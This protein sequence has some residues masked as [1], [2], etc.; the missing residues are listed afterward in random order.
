MKIKNMLCLIASTLA[1]ISCTAQ[2]NFETM[3]NEQFKKAIGKVDEVQLVD[4]RTPSEYEAGHINNAILLDC[5]ADSFVSRATAV[6]PKTKTVAVY[7]RSGRRSAMA[8]NL[9]T[10]AGYKVINL[11]GGILGWEGAGNEVVTHDMQVPDSNGYVV[12]EGQPY[13]DFTVTT[14]DGRTVRMRDLRG[15]VV[16]LQFTA[17]WCSVCRREMPHIESDIWQRHRTDS[18]FVLIGIDRDEPLEK[19]VK[20]AEQTGVTYPLALDPSAAVYSKF[21]LKDSGITRNVL[22]NRDGT[23]IFRTRLYK[24]DEF[25]RLVSR[26]DEELAKH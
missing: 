14:T 12:Y 25:K 13:P 10:E 24:E 5:K 17:S 16:M 23:I 1:G 26:I 2:G 18:N 21:A 15:K 19:V 7:C 8:A 22:V 4:V 6:L 11:D 3:N 9:L 20:F